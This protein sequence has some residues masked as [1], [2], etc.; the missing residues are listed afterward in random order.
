MTTVT[1]TLKLTPSQLNHL[2]AFTE[3]DYSSL[4][5]YF[6]VSAAGNYAYAVHPDGEEVIALVQVSDS[7]LKE[8]M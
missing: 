3:D 5:E 4:E 1:I 7:Q 6:A 8:D 2:K